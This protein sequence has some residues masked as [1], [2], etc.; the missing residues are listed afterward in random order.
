MTLMQ[1]VLMRA[2][3]RPQGILGRLGGA[4]MARMN[5]PF[6]N[7]VLDQLAVQPTDHL[8]EVGFGPGVIVRNL[9]RRAPEG[10]VAGVDA[11]PV[12]VEQARARCTAAIRSGRVD[13]CLG[14]AESLP[15]ADNRFDKALAINSMQVWQE[16]AAGLREI[17]RV[18]KPGGLVALGF[19]SYS[20]QARDGLLEQLSAAGFRASEMKETGNGFCALA[21]KP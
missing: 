14:S 5:E 15:F 21:R 13:L 3:G 8:L 11:S 20:G 19:T 4:I 2:F 12:M 1:S 18:L 17:R 16:P 10:H 9:S 6:G 7:W